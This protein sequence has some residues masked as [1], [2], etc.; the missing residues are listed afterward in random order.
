MT[1]PSASITA[2]RVSMAPPLRGARRLSVDIGIIASRATPRPTGAPVARSGEPRA[3]RDAKTPAR[4]TAPADGRGDARE[5]RAPRVR[6]ATDH[7]PRAGTVRSDGRIAPT[8]WPLAP[9][10]GA[11]GTGPT[12]PGYGAG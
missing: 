3:G 4:R 12:I 5:A 11:D 9:T 8:Y 1:W 10:N 2:T 6:E 7:G